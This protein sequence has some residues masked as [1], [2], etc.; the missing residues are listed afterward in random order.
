MASPLA[1]DEVIR[2]RASGK[3]NLALRS[4]PRRSDGYH[5]LATVFQAVSVYD[6]LAARWAEPG[7]FE[8]RREDL[9]SAVQKLLSEQG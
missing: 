1:E 2:V 5:E 8:L 9:V 3:I 4:G 6:D 7:Q